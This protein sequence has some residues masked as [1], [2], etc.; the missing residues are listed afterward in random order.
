ME[1]PDFIK[2]NGGDWNQ[3][4]V[5]TAGSKANSSMQAANSYSKSG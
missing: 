3:G 1:G 2:R 4:D 5:I